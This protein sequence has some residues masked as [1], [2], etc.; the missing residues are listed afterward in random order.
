M[1]FNLISGL[2]MQ[3]QTWHPPL[4]LCT[5]ANYYVKS[6]LTNV[7]KNANKTK[8]MHLLSIRIANYYI[9]LPVSR[10]YCFNV[11][12]MEIFNVV[13]YTVSLKI[14]VYENCCKQKQYEL[15]LVTGVILHTLL[16]R[17][18]L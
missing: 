8:N 18:G 4:C 3:I 11:F 9:T 6:G 17:L 15:L 10:F 5:H 14:H 13:C 12:E 2:H 1:N 7:L 16:K